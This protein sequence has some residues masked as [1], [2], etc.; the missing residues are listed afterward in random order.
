MAGRALGP[1]AGIEHLKKWDEAT[2]KQG[3]IFQIVQMLNPGCGL[4]I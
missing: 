2:E 1:A 3:P 4:S